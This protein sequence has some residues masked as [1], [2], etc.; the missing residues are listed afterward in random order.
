MSWKRKG[1]N[2]PVELLFKFDSPRKFH[3]VNIFTSNLLHLDIQVLHKHD[4]R[5]KTISIN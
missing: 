2:K 5:C 1:Q 3:K 4:I